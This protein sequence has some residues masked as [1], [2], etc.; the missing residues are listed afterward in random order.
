M[1]CIHCS[2]HVLY[3][4]ILQVDINCLWVQ[5]LSF[6]SLKQENDKLSSHSRVKVI[7]GELFVKRGI[8]TT[9]CCSLAVQ[10]ANNRWWRGSEKLPSPHRSIQE[11]KIQTTPQVHVHHSVLW[12][13]TQS[14]GTKRNVLAFTARSSSILV[15]KNANVC[16]LCAKS[17]RNAFDWYK[18]I[19]L[20]ESLVPG[21]TTWWK[22]LPVDLCS[23]MHQWLNPYPEKLRFVT[24]IKVLVALFNP[25]LCVLK[26]ITLHF[27]DTLVLFLSELKER[28]WCHSQRYHKLLS[29]V[30]S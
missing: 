9:G 16:S 17:G 23:F 30:A 26:A 3:V 24:L 13:G 28:D 7:D 10:E 8:Q 22:V 27:G 5:S 15:F 4:Y 2:Q 12:D 29:T 14:A 18:M 21:I 25:S 19:I 6:F 11:D 20:G 1:L